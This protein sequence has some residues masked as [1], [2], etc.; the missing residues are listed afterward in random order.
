M[1]LKNLLKIS[2]AAIALFAPLKSAA[3]TNEELMRAMRDELQRSMNEL[4]V[5]GLQKPYYIEYKVTLNNSYAVKSAL[6]SLVES[7]ENPYAT[8][9]VGVRVGNPQFDNTNF[10]DVGL[11]FFGSSD[12]EESFS[13]RRIPIETDYVTLRRELWLATD[14]A[15]KQAAELYS[16]KQSAIQN[17]LRTDTTPDFLLLPAA[18][19]IDTT[20]FAPFDAKHF[21]N[22]LNDVSAIF[23]NYPQISIS[24]VGVEYSPTT[25]L[26]VNTEG[27]EFVKN[28]TFTGLEIVAATQAADGMPLAQMYSAYSIRPQDL[29][30][31]D[32]LVKATR[33]LAEML[34]KSTTA[35]TLDEPYSGPVLFEGQAAAEVFAQIFAPNL[36]TQRAPLSDRGFRDSERFGAFQNKVGGRVLPEFLSLKATPRTERFK[37]TPLVGAYEIDDNG[38]ESKNVNLVEKGFLKTLLSSRIPTRRIRESNG[39]ERGGAAMLSILEL[40]S[41]DAKKQ[42]TNVELRKRLLKMAKDRALP[43]AIVVKKA[44]NQNILYTTLYRLTSGDYPFSP[45]ESK[46]P[47]LEVYKLYPDGREEL[48]RGLEGAGFSVQAFKDIVAVSRDAY[49][50]NYLAPAVTSPFITRGAQYL[51]STVIIPDLLF[52]DGEM[53]PLEADFPKP[54][55]LPAPMASK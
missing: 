6:G 22:V 1:L 18:R 21:E 54:P 53:R 24:Q 11:G 14:A 32:S 48:V 40:S 8:L 55:L 13:N 26:Y 39:H 30:N 28:E 31:R 5:A 51:P 25:T 44:L 42:M 19:L 23:K 45:S 35:T 33:N 38:I 15:Y 10:F 41:A 50:L 29:P 43:Y 12:D 49:A 16:K 47:V 52:E 46:V 2:V 7:E 27:R 3:V 34:F 4:A 36:V 37:N 20:A 17:R 9:S